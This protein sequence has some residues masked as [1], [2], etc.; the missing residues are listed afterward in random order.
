MPVFIYTILVCI[1]VERKFVMS[2]KQIIFTG[3][4]SAG[5]VIVNL[6]LIPILQEQGR[7]VDYIAS[8][9]G[10]QKKLISQLEGVTY[11]PI[12]TGKLR[13]YMSI[14]NFK[15]PFKVMNAVF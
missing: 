5:Q 12:S 13:R 14:E 10:T 8:K 1:I 15:D 7:K 6:A 4:G 3:D 9:H 2:E 11:H